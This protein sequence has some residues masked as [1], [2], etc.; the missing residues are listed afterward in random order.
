MWSLENAGFANFIVFCPWK[1]YMRYRSMCRGSRCLNSSYGDFLD[2]WTIG[3]A[4]WF[5]GEA[6]A[7]GADYQP[8]EQYV[9]GDL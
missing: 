6:A 3:D 2:L 1:L 7:S 4:E 8:T 9:A 5:D